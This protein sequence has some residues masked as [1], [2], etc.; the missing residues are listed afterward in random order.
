MSTS[1]VKSDYLLLFRGNV[2][3]RG[4]SPAQLQEVVSNWMAWFERLK[5]EG[6]CLGGHPLEEKGKVI[7]GKK[8]RTVADGPFAESKEAIGGYFY[9]TVADENEALEIAKQCPGL[10][11]GAVVEVRPVAEIC[12]VKQRAEE[13]SPGQLAGVTS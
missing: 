6:K 9:L 10:E 13:Y 7:S 2:W 1:T 11:Y 5:E 4:L 3:E 8:G 12:S